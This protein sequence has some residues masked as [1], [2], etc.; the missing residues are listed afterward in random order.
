MA[1]FSVLLALSAGNSP[2]TGEFPSQRPVT[3]SFDV[4]FDI[5]LNKRLSKQWWGWWFET[6]SL[7]RHRNVNVSLY[8]PN[9][10]SR[11]MHIHL[12]FCLIFWYR[13]LESRREPC[14]FV[15]KLLKS[16]HQLMIAVSIVKLNRQTGL[17]KSFIL[18]IGHINMAAVFL[19]AIQASSYSCQI[20]TFHLKIGYP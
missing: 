1:T 16:T 8:L 4:F 6:C 20:T 19:T 5:R 10:F 3:R 18:S 13:N 17:V 7:W 15:T 11:N 9:L 12:W 14:E 2:T